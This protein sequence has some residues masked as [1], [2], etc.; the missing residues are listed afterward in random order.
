MSEMQNAYKLLLN[1]L[2]TVFIEKPDKYASYQNKFEGN[3]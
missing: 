1:L 3:R 2:L